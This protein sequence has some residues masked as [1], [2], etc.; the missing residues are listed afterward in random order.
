MAMYDHTPRGSCD[1]S[2]HVEQPVALD[3]GDTQNCC[4]MSEQPSLCTK[5]RTAVA[6]EKEHTT[7]GAQLQGRRPSFRNKQLRVEVPPV[8]AGAHNCGRAAS[9]LIANAQAGPV[10]IPGKG[11]A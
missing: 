2:V 9:I 10:R 3:S 4:R 1:T 6:M 7:E 11:W 5:Q 8:A